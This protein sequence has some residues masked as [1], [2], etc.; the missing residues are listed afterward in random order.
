ML[1]RRN[2]ALLTPGLLAMPALAQETWPSRPIRLIVP[3]PAGGLTDR[4]GRILAEVLSA[5]LGQNVFVDNRGGAGGTTGTRQA[6]T[7]P[8]DGY[9]LAFA[10][11][12][13]HITGPLLYPNPGYDGVSDVV[14][15]GSFAQIGSVAV[16]HPSVPA[17]TIAE[18][19]A[20]CRA[21]PGK[22]N[23]GSAG[24]GGSVHLAGELFKMIAGV[25]IVHVPYRGG[26]LM[27]QDLLANRIQIAFDN[28]PQILPHVRSGGVRG[29]AVTTRER[30]R[31]APEL[32]TMIEAGVPDFEISSWFGV[33]A[34]IGTPPAIVARLSDIMRA[35]VSSTALAATLEVLNADPLALAPEEF[36]S[37]MRGQRA[38]FGEII[39]RLGIK[40]D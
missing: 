32:P 1:T 23:F 6:V 15:I 31:F 22:L 26:S 13:T 11:P 29:L 33:T 5:R 16:V 17:T 2:L 40:A 12:S 8:P 30:T 25:D 21:N 3:F 39:Q 34:P 10:A 27:L 18:L 4:M 20:H 38:R 14:P 28:T 35:A 9:T 24:A 7:A 37:F 36:G 19:V